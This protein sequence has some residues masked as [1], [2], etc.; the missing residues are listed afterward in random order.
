MTREQALAK[1][2]GAIIARQKRGE[3]GQNDWAAGFVDVL[4]VLGLIK[5][6]EPPVTQFERPNVE[7]VRLREQLER[8]ASV[9]PDNLT[10]PDVIYGCLYRA[11][12]KLENPA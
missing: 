2:A 12:I 1:V 6:D 3:Y 7:R 10:N 5:F 8:A 9:R 11:R 4:S